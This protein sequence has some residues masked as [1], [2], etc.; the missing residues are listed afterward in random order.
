[1][2]WSIIATWKMSY[3]GVVKA[4]EILK[5]GKTS[6]E[7]VIKAIQEVENDEKYHSVGYSGLP[8]NEGVL[9]MDAG[10]MDGKTLSFGAIASIEDFESPID[11]AAS[12]KDFEFNNFLVGKGA[13]KYA[14]KNHFKN[15][16]MLNEQSYQ[17]YLKK[18][19][20]TYQLNS[21]DGHDT[22]CVIAID[23]ESNICAGA[24][25][26]G[27]FMKSDGRVGDS[28]IIGCGFYADNNLGGACATG[29]GEDIMKGVLSYDI[30]MRM[31]YGSEVKMASENAVSE[32]TK[33]LISK[34]NKANAMSSIALDMDGN[35]GVGTNIKFAFVYASDKCEPK[36]Y[37]A[38]PK[39][40]DVNIRLA[41]ENDFDVD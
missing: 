7:A 8:N 26:S 18:K 3:V 30:L 33:R 12:L 24:S 23:N 15:K 22:V 36:I 17:L 16:K 32:L 19:E 31:K 34:R 35:Y 37:I 13:E 14:T 40:S 11:I 20:E 4:C 38:E 25:T 21:Y 41:D 5:N 28:P 27:L 10:F 2:S 39:G 1:M 6:K 29:V 9:Q